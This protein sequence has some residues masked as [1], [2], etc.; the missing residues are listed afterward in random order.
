MPSARVGELWMVGG[1]GFLLLVVVLG[2]GV[3]QLGPLAVSVSW[4]VQRWVL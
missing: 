3:G 4:S 1:G 2:L